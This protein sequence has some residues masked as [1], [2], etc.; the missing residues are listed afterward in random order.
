MHGVR[1]PLGRFR[2]FCLS[3][4]LEIIATVL[5]D[6]H[7]SLKRNCVARFSGKNKMTRLLYHTSRRTLITEGIGSRCQSPR[8]S[9]RQL[10][11]W[12]LKRLLV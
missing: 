3:Y 5:E 10:R 12:P 11:V 7:F 9:T 2:L 6:D 1:L 4:V 8:G